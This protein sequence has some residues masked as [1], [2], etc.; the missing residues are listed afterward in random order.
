[1]KIGGEE[2]LRQTEFI[3]IA[4]KDRWLLTDVD[5]EDELSVGNDHRTVTATL[6]LKK[7]PTKNTNKK[8]KRETIANLKSWQP[9]DNERY[10]AD[11]DKAIM[12]ECCSNP[13]W[14]TKS[15]TEKIESLEKLLILI[16]AQHTKPLKKE[17]AKVS[18]QDPELQRAIAGRKYYRQNKQYKEAAQMAKHAQRLTRKNSNRRIKEKIDQIVERFKGLK[19][20]HQIKK[21]GRSKRP[22]CMVH[23]NG[24]TETTARYGECISRLL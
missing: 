17:Q 12:A 16:A 23:P 6:K 10:A 19:W 18:E 8:G 9:R 15:N 24:K 5:T 20:V 1:M 3:M 14:N 7:R 11:L 22:H 2:N 21:G 13:Q 4:R